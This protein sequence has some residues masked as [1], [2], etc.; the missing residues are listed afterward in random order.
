MH[1]RSKS[2]MSI[3]RASTKNCFSTSGS[4]SASEIR[5]RLLNKLGIYNE[6]STKALHDYTGLAEA[7]KTDTA[8]MDLKSRH[9]TRI[10]ENRVE[11]NLQPSATPIVTNVRS[12]PVPFQVP[13]KSSQSDGSDSRVFA[14]SSRKTS[15]VTFDNAVSV[16][17][18]PMRTEYSSRIKN[19]IWS[20]RLELHVNVRRNTVEF[21]AEGW[22]WRNATEN[23]GMYICSVTGEL[24][25]PVHC[26]HYSK[27]KAA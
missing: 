17:P 18:I 23:D 14:T 9:R 26:R 16:L 10:H 3:S 20:D 24:V 19:R 2:I 22:N 15:A 27:R 13:L 12:S 25:H 8:V 7:N 5:A 4:G 1:T 6:K 11:Q 21:A